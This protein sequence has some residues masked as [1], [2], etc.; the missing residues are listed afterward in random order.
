MTAARVPYLKWR[1]GRPRWEPGPLLRKRGFKGIDLKD[2]A[3]AWLSR[4]ASK[5]L[6]RDINAKLAE[7]ATLASA[8]VDAAR[9]EIA[10]KGVWWA[11]HE[12]VQLRRSKGRA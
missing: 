12:I 7:A 2:E 9:A 5:H 3:G 10:A 1:A 6:A 8:E 11:A 4:E